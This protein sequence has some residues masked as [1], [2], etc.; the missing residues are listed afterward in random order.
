MGSIAK[1]ETV[2]VRE[3]WKHE[4]RGF[5][6]WLAENLDPLGE[7]VGLTLRNPIREKE[8]GRFSLDVLAETEGGA[9]VIIE[10]QLDLTNHDHL[11]KVLTYL[12][13]LEAK[14]AV[15]IAGDIREEHAEAIRWLNEFT[16]ADT[17]FYLVKLSAFRIN[18]SDPAPHFVVVAG[19]TETG[20]SVGQEKKELA[21]RQ[22]LLLKFWGQLLERARQRGVQYH[23]QRSPGKD[24]W[25]SAG[26]GIK[27]GVAYN[28]N[29]WIDSAAADLWIQT[30]SAAENKRI[31]DHLHGQR[32][33]VEASFG[34]PLIWDRLDDKRASR[35]RAE[36][37]VGGLYEPEAQWPKIQDAVIDAMDRLVK[38]LR[39]HYAGL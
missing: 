39:P 36:V 10:N 8:V 12:S 22:V 25:L 23:A 32:E 16:P 26:A 7:A 29:V 28:Y 5:S 21:G 20:R 35:V 24:S 17:A 2:A 38:A 33:K 13:N 15:W 11:G 18:G 31:F 37:K 27:S 3:L 19:P 4:E 1:L 34:G 6:A 9:Q 30:E 14:I